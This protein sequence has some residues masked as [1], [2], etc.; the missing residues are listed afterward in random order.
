MNWHVC[1]SGSN[2][3]QSADLVV[4]NCMVPGLALFG[5]L[6]FLL[7]AGLPSFMVKSMSPTLVNFILTYDSC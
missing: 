5:I 6:A 4:C 7:C 3:G 2:V 1:V